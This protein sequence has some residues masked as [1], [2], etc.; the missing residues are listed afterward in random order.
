[1][2]WLWSPFTLLAIGYVALVAVWFGRKLN[3]NEVVSTDH[4]SDGPV[5]A[6]QFFWRPG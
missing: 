1:M 5:E 6:I 3:R 4:R 2:E